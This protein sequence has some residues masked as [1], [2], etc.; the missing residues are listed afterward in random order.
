MNIVVAGP[1]SGVSDVP[2]HTTVSDVP[3][4]NIALS[5]TLSTP[6]SQGRVDMMLGFP[7]N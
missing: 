2:R 1:D 5:D 4:Q 3:K 7:N 6:K